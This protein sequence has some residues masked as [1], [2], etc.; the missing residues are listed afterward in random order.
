MDQQDNKPT[1]TLKPSAEIVQKALAEVTVQAASGLNITLK[2]P[3]VL[4]Q[5]R[6][7]EAL[8]DTAENRTYTSMVLPL[9]YVAAIDGDPVYPPNSK[10]EVEALI[11]R[12]DDDGLAAVAK[13]VQAHFSSST[14]DQDKA[15]LK[16]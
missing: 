14:P 10:V 8:G 13:G 6:L 2:K 3:G 1:I 4:A 9:I 11:Q 7:I 5:F 15:A 12:L 16:K